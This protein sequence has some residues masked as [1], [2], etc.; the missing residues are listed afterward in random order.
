MTLCRR[1][2]SGGHFEWMCVMERR[3]EERGDGL[4]GGVED[5]PAA[6]QHSRS[7]QLFFH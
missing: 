1:S 6:S 7:L 4:V 2:S 3:G 5:Y